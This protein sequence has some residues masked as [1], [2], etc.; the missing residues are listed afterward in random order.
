MYFFLTFIILV[1][2]ICWRVTNFPWKNEKTSFRNVWRSSSVHTSHC[3]LW[4]AIYTK[5]H[6]L[7][8]SPK[9][10]FSGKSVIPWSFP[11][12][13]N[14]ISEMTY[15]NHSRPYIHSLTHSLTHSYNHSF[16]FFH[17][18]VH[19]FI[20]SLPCLTTGPQALP[21]A[22]IQRLQSSAS[23][24]N[25]QYPRFSLRSSSSSLYLLPRILFTPI[26]TSIFLSI[27]CFRRQFLCQ[28]C[29]IQLAFLHLLDVG[30]SSPPGLYVILHF[31]YDH[32]N[33]FLHLSPAT[34]IETSHVLPLHFGFFF[35]EILLKCKY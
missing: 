11:S 19:S 6:I 33:W 28:I 14:V 12:N 22:V 2:C 18:Y 8:L 23:S 31:S 4:Q 15:L 7:K 9:H 3:Y 25:L 35:K 10:C 13:I 24:F 32:S 29:Q 20:H 16:I 34:N 17:T 21:K 1:D 5:L 26:L 27:T 30:Y